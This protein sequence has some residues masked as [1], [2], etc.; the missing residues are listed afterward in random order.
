MGGEVEQ[1]AAREEQPRDRERARPRRQGQDRARHPRHVLDL[2]V[3][4]WRNPVQHHQ[5]G[6]VE[7]QQHAGVHQVEGALHHDPH[8]VEQRRHQPHHLGGVLDV[9]LD[10]GE[11]AGLAALAARQR[12]HHPDHGPAQPGEQPQR[13]GEV[14]GHERDVAM[15]RDHRLDREFRQH[16]DP[17]QQRERQPLRDEELGGLGAPRHH[18]GAHQDRGKGPERLERGARGVSRGGEG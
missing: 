4:L 9:Q 18:E 3:L 10:R 6:A 15:P 17:G 7:R 13:A 1:H 14:R 12:L 16:L 11:E 8:E 5:V 2:L